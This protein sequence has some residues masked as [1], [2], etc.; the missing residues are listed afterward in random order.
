MLTHGHADAEEW[1]L[2]TLFRSAA[3]FPSRVASCPQRTWAILTK[4]DNN[5][6]FVQW[7]GKNKI[8]VPQYHGA[9][10]YTYGLLDMYMEYKTNIARL[11]AVL[12]NPNDY[13]MSSVPE[14]IQPTVAALV[15]KRRKMKAQMGLIV[16]EIDTLSVMVFL[17]DQ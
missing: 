4:Y 13:V 14:A 7:A 17:C 2:E 9:Q 6:D 1:S 8:R 3:A 11:Q 5:R 16:E 15:Q 10:A 12:Q